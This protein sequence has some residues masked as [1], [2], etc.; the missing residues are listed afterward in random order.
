MTAPKVTASNLS[1]TRGK[2]RACQQSVVGVGQSV[3]TRHGVGRSPARADDD[4][5]D[6]EG[7]SSAAASAAVAAGRCCVSRRTMLSP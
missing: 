7:P 2:A 6:D 3:R 1:E 5:D 4:D